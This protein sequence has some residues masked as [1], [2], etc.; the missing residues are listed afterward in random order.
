MQIA[1]LQKSLAQD[2]GNTQ[3]DMVAAV[4]KGWGNNSHSSE[5][6]HTRT[7]GWRSQ[8]YVGLELTKTLN[9][10]PARAAL[11]KAKLAVEEKELEMRDIKSRTAVRRAAVQRGYSSARQYLQL[12]KKKIEVAGKNLANEQFKIEAGRSTAI[13]VYSARS[14]LEQAQSEYIEAMSRYIVAAAQLYKEMGRLD[15]F[16]GGLSIQRCAST[17]QLAR[18]AGSSKDL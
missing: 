18:G 16:V 3:I 6:E 12:I 17:E 1:K 7:R 13:L 5:V 2:S 9:D 15:E 10:Y 14:S 4:G 11:R 8:S